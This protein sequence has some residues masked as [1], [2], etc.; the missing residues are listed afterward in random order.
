[1]IAQAT[2]Y[3]TM[4]Q[5][6]IARLEEAIAGPHINQAF[7]EYP[8]IRAPGPYIL[9]MTKLLEKALE[10][11]DGCPPGLETKPSH[12]RLLFFSYLC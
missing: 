2:P 8:S 10:A 9:S 7:A 11:V 4:T 3:W 6:D 5:D 12:Q 1:M